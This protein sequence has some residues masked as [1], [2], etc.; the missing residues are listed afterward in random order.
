MKAGE[1]LKRKETKYATRRQA[2]G[3]H[4]ARRADARCLLGIVKNVHHVHE[5]EPIT[6]ALIRERLAARDRFL[7]PLLRERDAI[8]AAG[9]DVG[10]TLFALV[11]RLVDAERAVDR[12]VWLAAAAVLVAPCEHDQR[13]TLAQR[14]ARRVRAA[15]RLPRASAIASSAR[16]CAASGMRGAV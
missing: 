6:D 10:A 15:F 7:E 3:R 4:A 13:V 11:D 14:A 8:L 2:Q 5:A 1:S 12:S 16:F 9:R